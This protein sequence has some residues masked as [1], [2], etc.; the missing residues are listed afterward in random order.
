MSC[1]DID[2]K[3]YLLEELSADERQEAE[4]HLSGCEACREEYDRLQ[5][6]QT[7]LLAVRDEEIPRRIAFVSDKVFEP[8]WWQRLWRPGPQWAFGAAAMLSCAILVHAFVRPGPVAPGPA[9]SVETA[10]I[11]RMVEDE[12][13]RRLESAVSQAVAAV[14]ARHEARTEELLAEAKR[15]FEAESEAN[16]VAFEEAVEYLQKSR[17]TSFLQANYAPEGVR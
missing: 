12:V 16:R 13:E 11:E 4:A 1:S 7:A 15:T 10:A 9:P 17:N 5:L 8:S 6:T 14:E 2:I 3:G